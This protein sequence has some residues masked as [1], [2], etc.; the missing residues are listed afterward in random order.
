V[1]V[2][3]VLAALALSAGCGGDEDGDATGA[4][5]TP[6]T[7]AIDAATRERLMTLGERVFVRHCDFCHRLNGKRP[8]RT[9][10]PDAYG[11]SFDQIKPTQAYV[12]DRVTNGITAMGS[13]EGI[14][15]ERRIRAVALYVSTVAGRDVVE[16]EPSDAVMAAGE[17]VFEEHCRRCHTLADR[18]RLRKPMWP[19]TDFNHVKPSAAFVTS[20]LNGEGNKFLIE[21]MLP[22]QGKL[23]QDEIDAVAAYVSELGGPR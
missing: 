16:L 15:S 12:V 23:S 2:G 4:T 6:R 11:P 14:L 18:V 8:A 1:L 17:R 19:A 7:T 5:R 10:P 13:F 21:F 9:P 3:C 22:L 20:L